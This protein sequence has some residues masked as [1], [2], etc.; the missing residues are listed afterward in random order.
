M[1]HDDYIERLVREADKDRYLATVFAPA[2]KRPALLA[3]YAFCV[4][5]S[6]VREMVSEPMPGEIRLQWWRDV[7]E[8][9]PTGDAAGHPTARAILDVVDRYGLPPH[10]FLDLIEARVF[11]LY[12]DPMPTLHDLEGYAGETSG[13]ILQLAS[14]I[15]NDGR[16]PKTGEVAGHA[17]VALTICAILRAFPLHASRRQLYVPLEVLDRHGAR[18]ADI[19]AGR[20]TPEIMAALAEM[21]TH[22]RRHIGRMAEQVSTLPLSVLPAFLPVALVRG[23]LNRMD[24]RG[25]DPFTT[26]VQIPQWRRQATMWLAARRAARRMPPGT[27]A[28]ARQPQ[29]D[30]AE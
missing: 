30:A 7:F 26:P 2:D 10:A 13:A 18:T 29:A 23:Y 20:V 6:R 5:I 16:D 21:R 3:L 15:L 4:E 8:G 9:A 1:A 22:A 27:P 14:L 12:D 28:S 24:H 17:G 25:Y 19:F 11:D